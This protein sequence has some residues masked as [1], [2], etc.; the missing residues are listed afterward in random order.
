MS[1]V[2]WQRR[3]AVRVGAVSFVLL[4]SAAITSSYQPAAKGLVEQTCTVDDRGMAVL[5]DL[6]FRAVSGT[7]SGGY[8]TPERDLMGNH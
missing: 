5:I 1:D 7:A 3:G 2:G 8:A 4:V 6:K